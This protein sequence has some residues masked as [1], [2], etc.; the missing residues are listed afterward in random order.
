MKDNSF[1]LTKKKSRR[2]PTHTITDIE[3]PD[4]VA[5]LANIPAQAET[6]LHSPKR[7]AACIGL[8]VNADK[9]EYMFLNLRGN[10]STLNGSSLKLYLFQFKMGVGQFKMGIVNFKMGIVQFKREKLL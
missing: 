1:K 6:L 2:Y 10:I 8:H 7:A 5:F 9:T 3:Y 4:D